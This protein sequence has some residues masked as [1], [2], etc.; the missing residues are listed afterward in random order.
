[1]LQQ[2]TPCNRVLLSSVLIEVF[3]LLVASLEHTNSSTDA[4]AVTLQTLEKLIRKKKK[5]E[6]QF[7]LDNTNKQQY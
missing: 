6:S 4:R 5:K 2:G 1:M 7:Y 3:S